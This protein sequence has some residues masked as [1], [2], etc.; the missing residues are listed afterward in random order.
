ME[1]GLHQCTQNTGANRPAGLPVA[2]SCRGPR[3]APKNGLSAASCA[4]VA[5]F[6]G[7]REGGGLL[8]VAIANTRGHAYCRSSID[9]AVLA[10]LAYA[11]PLF[12]AVVEGL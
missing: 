5:R 11:S 3:G 6:E 10:L 12:T 1:I 8:R 7:K 2:R 9:S 4:G